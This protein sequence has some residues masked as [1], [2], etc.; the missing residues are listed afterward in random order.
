MPHDF[1][2]PH[3]G[4]GDELETGFV[5]DARPLHGIGEDT[6][7]LWRAGPDGVTWRAAFC[8]DTDDLA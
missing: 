8:V 2:P 7:Q 3:S 4:G 6:A 5:F 1:R